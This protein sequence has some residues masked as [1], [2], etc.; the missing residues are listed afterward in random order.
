MD[1]R[2]GHARVASLL[3]LLFE[4]H[5]ELAV[6]VRAGRGLGADAPVEH[7]NLSYFLVLV[8]SKLGKACDAMEDGEERTTSLRGR[9]RVYQVI[10]WIHHHF[11][12]DEDVQLVD[13]VVRRVLVP[14]F[15]AIQILLCFLPATGEGAITH[16]NDSGST[17]PLF[18]LNLV[19][20]GLYAALTGAAAAL[21]IEKERIPFW[22]S[23]A[24]SK[25]PSWSTVTSP[26]A[27]SVETRK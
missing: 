26:V 12:G 13:R 15:F 14:L 21:G 22:K 17:S 19:C 1:K 7:G 18:I 6:R 10:F 27:R 9:S 16:H 11:F 5:G 8:S 20:L 2:Y 4:R 3:A 23:A 25:L 24:K